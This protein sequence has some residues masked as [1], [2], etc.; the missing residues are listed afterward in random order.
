MPGAKDPDEY[1]KTF[2]VEKFKEVIGAAKSKFDYKLDGALGKYDLNLPQDKI[3]AI[4]D[5]VKMISA[6]YSAAERDVYIRSISDKLGVDFASIRSDV[7]RLI[8]RNRAAAKRDEV[9]RVHE[10]AT[11]YFDKVNPDYIKAPA[12]AKSEEVVLGLMLAFVDH[13]RRVFKDELISESDFFTD[14]NRRIFSYLKKAY[15]ESNEHLYD[16]SDVFTP[17]ES[18][19]I[20]KMRIARLNISNGEDVLLESISALKK[21]VQ[22][23]ASG[24]TTSISDLESIIK[25]K[26]SE[27]K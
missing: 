2:G 15:E 11:G 5:A 22:N 6:V 7:E 17:E 18:G 13:R 26:Q 8:A 12:V 25:R 4:N 16:I 19:R 10:T 20:S 23:N 14:L 21:T 27:Q 1:I 9:K 24:Q 3:N